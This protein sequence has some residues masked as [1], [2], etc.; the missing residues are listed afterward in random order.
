MREE[1]MIIDPQLRVPLYFQLKE[2][3]RKDILR[4]VFKEGDL[5]PSEREFAE[6]YHLSSTTI[7]RALNDL[8]HDDLLERKAGKGTFVRKQMVRRDLKKVLG[9]TANMMEMGLTP[10]TKVLEMEVVS[11]NAFARE[12][13]GLK[14]GAKVALIKRLRLANEIPMMLETRYIREDI[15]P[16]ILRYDLSSSLWEVFEKRYGYQPHR[17]SQNLGLSYISG[18]L[19]KLLGLEDGSVVFLIRGV[20]YI[21]DGRAIECEESL[22]RSDKYDLAFDAVAE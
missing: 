8:V 6:K 16:G 13:M 15:C 7:R 19:A 1:L 2:E 12:K 10:S 18:E 3:L 20:T 9:F 22:Y 11:A 21:K 5:I 17:H 4:G 14:R